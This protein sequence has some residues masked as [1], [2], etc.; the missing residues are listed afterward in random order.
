MLSE[1]VADFDQAC[2]DDKRAAE[3]RRSIYVNQCARAHYAQNPHRNAILIRQCDRRIREAEE[4][5]SAI[6]AR[7]HQRDL[8]IL[9]NL[10]DAS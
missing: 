3:L 10:E 4:E 2:A 1:K 9:A 7:D 8:E 6:Q 5:L